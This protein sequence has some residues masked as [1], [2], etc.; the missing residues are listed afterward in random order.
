M[1]AYGV[2]DGEAVRERVREEIGVVCRRLGL[3]LDGMG[4]MGE[5]D[6]DLERYYVESKREFKM[7]SYK[8]Q[9]ELL[10]LIMSLFANETLTSNTSTFNPT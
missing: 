6:G 10:D 8:E 3:D 2:V 9:Q 1:S 5:I 7:P 4:E